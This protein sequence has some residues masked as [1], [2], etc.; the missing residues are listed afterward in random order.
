MA[1]YLVLVID[2]GQSLFDSTLTKGRDAWWVEARRY[3][4]V[5]LSNL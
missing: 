2:G 1:N 5:P 4:S 3:K